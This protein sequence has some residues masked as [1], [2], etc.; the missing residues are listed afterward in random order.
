MTEMKEKDFD[1]LEDMMDRMDVKR[2]RAGKNLEDFLRASSGIN[3]LV[4]D[5]YKPLSFIG[6][7]KF[8]NDNDK[9]IWTKWTELCE[10]RDLCDKAY[11]D[12]RKIVK[13]TCI[14]LTGKDYEDFEG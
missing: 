10:E 2:K 9:A 7:H 11:N 6:P 13:Y 5:H 12:L 8:I 14:A 3:A 4:I 1:M